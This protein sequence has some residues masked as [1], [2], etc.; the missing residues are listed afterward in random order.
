MID[1]FLLDTIDWL[2]LTASDQ[3][4]EKVGVMHNFVVDARCAA[5]LRVLILDRVIAVRASCD[6]LL[7]AILLHR[8]DVRLGLCLV[9]QLLTHTP[10]RIAGAGLFLTEN[11]EIDAS[12][13]KELD[14]R[15]CHT[16]AAFVVARGAANPVEHIDALLLG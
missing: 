1:D 8:L 10:C 16:T 12:G 2:Q 5:E 11:G 9:E 3:A 6:Q 7:E 4:G 15:A 14:H 13:L